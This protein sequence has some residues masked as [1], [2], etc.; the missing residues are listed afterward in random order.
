[1]GFKISGPQFDP[2]RAGQQVCLPQA[3]SRFIR[4]TGHSPVQCLPPGQVPVKSDFSTDRFF[5]PLRRDRG[6]IDAA[7]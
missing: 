3:P 4:Q 1:M 5:F 2:Y 7:S 6:T